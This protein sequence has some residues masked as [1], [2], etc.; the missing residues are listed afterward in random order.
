ME[1]SIFGVEIFG[2][3]DFLEE[4]ERVDVRL[5]AAM[6]YYYS[7]SRRLK[8]GRVISFLCVE[9]ERENWRKIHTCQYY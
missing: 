7:F 1:K 5:D 9:L 3:K 8:K 4:E 6:F 2:M